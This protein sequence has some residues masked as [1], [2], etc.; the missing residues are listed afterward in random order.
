MTHEFVE[1]IPDNLEKEKIYI[2]IKYNI[3]THSCC[4][5]CGNEVVTPISP[6]DWQL[7]YY[8]NSISLHPSIGNWNFDCKSHYWI[9]KNQVQWSYEWSDEEIKA[10]REKDKQIKDEYYQ[11]ISENNQL[12]PEVEQKESLP[13]ELGFWSWIKKLFSK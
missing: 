8:G 11:I 10:G 2:S 5:G 9:K 3:V 4:C 13:K 6:T 1:F 7:T 12:T